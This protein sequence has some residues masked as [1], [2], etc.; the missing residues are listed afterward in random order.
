MLELARIAALKFEDFTEE[1]IEKIRG[2]RGRDGRDGRDGEDFKLADHE[3]QVRAWVREF[4]L[5]FSDFTAEEIEQIR[6]PRGADGRDGKDFNFD[7][8]RESIQEMIRNLISEIQDGLKLRFSD[9]TEEDIEQIRGPRGRDGRDGKNF[10]F[11]EHREFFETLRPKFSDFTKEEREQLVLRFSHLTD[12]EKSQLKLRFEDLTDE[13]RLKLRGA[14]GPRGQRGLAGRDGAE[15]KPGKDGLS[16]RGL[17]GPSGPV[18]RSGTN[19][20]D[21]IDGKDGLDAPYIV[22]IDL[23]VNKYNEFWFVFYFSNGDTLET[24]K[25]KFPNINQYFFPG[26]GVSSIAG[27]GGGGGGPSVVCGTEVSGNA[28]NVWALSGVFSGGNTVY[29]LPETP[30]SD[31][32]VIVWLDGS[33]RTDYAILGPQITFVGQ[34]TTSQVF[35]AHIRYD[36]GVRIYASPK[37][38][39]ALPGIFSGGDTKYTLP[40]TPL[41]PDE[42]IVWLNGTM[43]T[44]YV[45]AGNEVQFIGLDTTGQVFDAHYR[46]DN[47]TCPQPAAAQSEVVL[48]NV[49]CD[50]TVYVKAAVKMIG[51]TAFNALADSLANSNVIG[52]VESKPSSTLC[53]IRV[54]GVS[55]GIFSG[56]DETKEYFLSDTVDGEI[57]TTV[58]TASG[59]IILR[60]GQ[61]FSGTKLLVL[62]GVRI[63]RA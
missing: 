2:P 31:E 56:L 17:P 46:Y 35:D 60:V 3:E 51:G 1:Q 33:Q 37:N 36:G 57:T 5:K 28:L 58:P 62:K 4:A 10:S 25:E 53:N 61:P 29:T 22:S 21:G 50:P 63:E 15:G 47:G 20:R 16:I 12:E 9:L 27:S 40:D 34:D 6:G 23:E 43:R 54:L 8:S 13:E 39:S 55:P 11:E 41:T 24:D 52:V 49:P 42:L 48:Y 59:H 38:L 30:T 26:G 19:G 14:R 32:E 44:D 45:L 7:E 18:G